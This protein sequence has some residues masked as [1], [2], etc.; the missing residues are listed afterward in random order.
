MIMKKVLC[1]FLSA[2]L[3]LGISGCDLN[4]TQKGAI[5]GAGGGAAAGAVIVA[6]C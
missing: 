1:A 5:Y 4:N 3:L 2:A 6:I